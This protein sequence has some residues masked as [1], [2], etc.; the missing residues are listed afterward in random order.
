MERE[1][2]CRH[3]ATRNRLDVEEAIRS[4]EKAR[5]GRCKGALFLGPEEP[6]TGLDPRAYEHPL[7]RQALEALRRV[8]GTGTFLIF[9]FVVFLGVR[10]QE[11]SA[12]AKVVNFASNLAAMLLFAGRGLVVWSVALPMAAGQFA[13][14]T[15]G[16]HLAVRGGDRLVRWVVLAVVSALVVKLGADLLRGS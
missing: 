11:A 10:L 6:F 12:D 13:G 16:A 3:C 2:G 8:P 5:C 15:M 1:I 4:P 9:G 14:A 7:D